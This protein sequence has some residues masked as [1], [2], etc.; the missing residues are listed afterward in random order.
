MPQQLTTAFG[1]LLA[2]IKQFSLAQRTLALLGVAILL[3]GI[4]ALGAWVA[5]PQMRALYTDLAPADASPI[6]EMLAGEGVPY[7]LT[8]GGG[9]IMIPADQVYSQ[10]LKVASSG[11]T[12][13]SK[14][15]YSLLDNMG[16]TTSVFQQNVT[17]KRALEGELA[18]TLGAM[19]GVEMATVQLA[20]P[21]DS[22]F[23]S[24]KQDP[25]ASVFIKPVAGTTFTDDQVQ[26]MV[27]FVSSSI[28]GLKPKDVSVIDAAGTVLTTPET[29]GGSQSSNKATSEYEARVTRNVQDMLD[30]IV[31]TGMAVVSVTAEL[32][33]DSTERTS[34]SFSSN[35]DVEPL[36]ERTTTEQFN[37]SNN[38]TGVLGPDN[39]AVPN[40][41]E[42][43]LYTNTSEER[44]NAVD[45]VTEH[46]VTAPGTVRKQ[47]ISVAVDQEAAGGL[48]MIDL[49][50]MVASAAGIDEER[51]DV[52]SVSRL[53]F[54]QSAAK[55]AQAA[56]AQAEAELESAERHEL[57]RMLITAAVIVV[58]LIVLAILLGR[59]RKREIEEIEEP[60]EEGTYFDQEP[61][62][63]G[64]VGQLLDELDETPSMALLPPFLDEAGIAA[65]QRRQDVI[66]L[67]DE[68]PEE[69]ANV[70]RELMNTR[71]S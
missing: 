37:G 56:I 11:I 26:A 27:Q 45:K 60:I 12:P 55:T 15:G 54:D 8:N 53:R 70:L 65:D 33:Y 23:V 4:I 39:I 28:E 30:R 41:Q 1:K 3:V 63:S 19:T 29:A 66:S 64:A 7:E 42:D 18:D 31:G 40:G 14:S 9:T 25:S 71:S 2:A 50:K 48:N 38:A 5:K 16:M 10:R 34:E 6:V 13:V 32:D 51:G 47:S 21:E 22:V 62:S 61:P 17:Y 46:T 36:T 57:Y 35:E 44:N 59:R 24:Q 67:A 69:V 49:S 20:L 58:A 52:V 43:G 68:E